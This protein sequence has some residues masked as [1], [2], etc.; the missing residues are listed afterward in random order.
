MP[1][2]K[3]ALAL[4]RMQKGWTLRDN[5]QLPPTFGRMYHLHWSTSRA[6]VKNG[7]VT[8]DDETK[9]YRI[10]DAGRGVLAQ[11]ANKTTG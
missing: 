4:Y 11:Y 6:L 7:W 1:T 5:L 9:E 8:W 2:D 10:N 3:Q